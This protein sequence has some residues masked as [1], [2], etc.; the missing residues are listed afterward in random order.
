MTSVEA[1]WMGVPIVT[2]AG[3]TPA[4]RQTGSFL[5]LLGLNDLITE[6]QEQ[7]VT[8][9]VALAKDRERL[10]E[11][12]S[13][14]RLKMKESPLMNGS[15]FAQNMQKLFKQMVSERGGGSE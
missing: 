5:R 6:N 11:I 14:L 4:S 3:S 10:Y 12:R 13:G 1:L 2:L 7:F 9:S 15:L 8:I